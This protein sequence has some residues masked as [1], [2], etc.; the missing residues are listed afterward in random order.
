MGEFSADYPKLLIFVSLGLKRKNQPEN[1]VNAKT[2]ALWRHCGVGVHI[3]LVN[4]FVPSVMQVKVGFGLWYG[5][6]VW[7][8][9]IC[10]LGFCLFVF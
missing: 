1:C 6:V 4:V 2:A 5:F 3:L 9:G 10:F 8:W 7:F